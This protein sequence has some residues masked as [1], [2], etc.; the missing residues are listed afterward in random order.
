MQDL[1]YESQKLK[2]EEAAALINRFMIC[3]IHENLSLIHTLRFGVDLEESG[4][5]FHSYPGL[6]TF[7]L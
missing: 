7:A 3:K 5:P 6:I 4:K 1:D 2:K